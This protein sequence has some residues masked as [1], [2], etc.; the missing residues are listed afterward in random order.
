MLNPK[1]LIGSMSKNKSK[2]LWILIKVTVKKEEDVAD[3]FDDLLLTK[4]C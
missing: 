1:M 2:S 3:F 4:N